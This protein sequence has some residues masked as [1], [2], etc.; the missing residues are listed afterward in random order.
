MQEAWGGVISRIKTSTNVET[1]EVT[2]FKATEGE[3]GACRTPADAYR[4]PRPRR[5]GDA[6]TGGRCLNASEPHGRSA[7]G[8]GDRKR[9]RPG[10]DSLPNG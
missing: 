7:C 3:K 2:I 4:M 10:L 9:G 8:D 6:R 5:A 1:G